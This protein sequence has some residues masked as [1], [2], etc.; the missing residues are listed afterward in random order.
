MTSATSLLKVS[1]SS[2][3]SAP[4]PHPLPLL[5][6]R[7]PPRSR[8]PQALLSQVFSPPSLLPNVSSPPFLL[9]LLTV[10]DLKK[11]K[12]KDVSSWNLLVKKLFFVDQKLVW[13]LFSK[14]WLVFP[15]LFL[16]DDSVQQTQSHTCD[17]SFFE[18]RSRRGNGRGCP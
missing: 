15:F 7:L 3:E 11:K 1:A 16:R 8:C 6:P 9:L 17:V 10:L 5:P 4:S 14:G 12:K 2:Q 13:L 18:I